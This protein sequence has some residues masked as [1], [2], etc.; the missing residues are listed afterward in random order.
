MKKLILATIFLSTFFL[1]LGQASALTI[2]FDSNDGGYVVTNIGSVENPWSYASGGWY[3]N[4]TESQGVPTASLLTSP[5]YTVA[6]DGNVMLSFDHRYSFEYDGTRQDGGQV[7][8][9]I[10][11]GALTEVP[12]SSFSQNGY[13]GIIAGN[14]ILTGQNGF[15]SDSPGY[16][17]PDF[18]SSVAGLGIFSSGDTFST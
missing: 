11:G 10:N 15:N 7:K 9:S 6:S 13:I 4:G 2:N 14:N 1:L 17:N 8:I 5:D 3:T 16:S 18:V 12:N